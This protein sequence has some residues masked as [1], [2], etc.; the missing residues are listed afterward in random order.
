MRVRFAASAVLFVVLPVFAAERAAPPD[1][2]RAAAIDAAA[3]LITIETLNLAVPKSNG[4]ALQY[5]VQRIVRPSTA[6]QRWRRFVWDLKNL[7]NNDV[8][9]FVLVGE[10]DLKPKRRTAIEDIP[11]ALKNL[12]V[13]NKEPRSYG[14]GPN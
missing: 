1:D 12:F 8:N 7:A 13:R 6:K 2:A 14:E 9:P 11:H 10:G 3:T 5:F 4:A